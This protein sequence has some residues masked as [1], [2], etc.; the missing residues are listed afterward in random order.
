MDHLNTS[1]QGVSG[2]PFRSSPASRP[3]CAP[4][5]PPKRSVEWTRDRDGTAIVRVELPNGDIAKTDAESFRALMLTGVSPNWTFNLD[6]RREIGY[7]RVPM[8]GENARRGNLATV[9]RL[10]MQAPPGSIVHY[11]DRDHFNLRRDNL[12]VFGGTK[13][14]T[15]PVGGDAAHEVTF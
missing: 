6:G 10:I 13:A 1:T 5:L 8:S 9:A 4:A 11:L 12:K 2:A 7:V 3:T 15:D 14:G